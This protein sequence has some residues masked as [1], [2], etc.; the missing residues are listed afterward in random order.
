MIFVLKPDFSL[1]FQRFFYR[2]IGTSIGAVAVT[3]LL[4]FINDPF[5]LNCIGFLAISLAL[6]LIRFHYSLAVF[7]ITL[8]ALI[9]SQVY[10]DNSSINFIEA[11]L[12]CTL[13]GAIFAFLLSFGLGRPKEELLFKN[14]TV[15]AIEEINNYFQAV[16]AI[17]LGEDAYHLNKIAEI[18]QKARLAHVNLDTALQRLINDPNT[19]LETIEPAI[20]LANYVP[21]LGRGAKMLH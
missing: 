7:F 17:Y 4:A 21:R 20:T 6:S 18:R 1:T 8:F 11:R 12:I 2:V 13:I 15:K 10:P 14:A 16:M 19:P 5:V 9:L 3:V